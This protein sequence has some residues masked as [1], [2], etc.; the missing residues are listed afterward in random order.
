MRNFSWI[1]PLGLAGVAK[2]GGF[3]LLELDLEALHAEGV[4]VLVSLTEQPLPPSA[5]EAQGLQPV[6]IPVVDF[7]PP[8]PPQL[9]EFV[10]VVKDSWRQGLPVAVHCHAGQGRTGTMLAAWLV[11]AGMNPQAAIRAIRTARPGS[12]ETPEQEAAIV[13]F[14]AT[15]AAQIP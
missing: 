12:I 5:L 10:G 9:L 1:V 13:A 14:E 8:S 6:H 2:P 11:S 15:W 7:T 3:Q 4:R